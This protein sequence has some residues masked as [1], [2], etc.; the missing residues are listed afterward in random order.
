MRCCYVPHLATYPRHHSAHSPFYSLDSLDSLDP[1]SLSLDGHHRRTFE[2]LDGFDEQ[3]DRDRDSR[4]RSSPS[5]AEYCKPKYTL[6]NTHSTQSPG[7]DGRCEYPAPPLPPPV[8]SDRSRNQHRSRSINYSSCSLS[9]SL[10]SSPLSDSRFMSFQ[11]IRMHLRFSQVLNRSRDNTTHTVDATI[12]G[13]IRMHLNDRP[14]LPL[15]AAS[16]PGLG[17]HGVASRR[18]G[19]PGLKLSDIE[20][21]GSRA[22]AAGLAQGRPSVL[23][24]PRK[25]PSAGENGTP[26]ANFSKIVYVSASLL[27]FYIYIYIYTYTIPLSLSLSLSLY[28]FLLLSR[29]PSGALRFT[30]KAVLHAKGV[31]FS[32]GASFSINMSEFNLQ[33]ELGKGFYG[34]VRK[35]LHKPT[36]VLMAM[37]VPPRSPLS[38]SFLPPS[39]LTPTNRKSAFN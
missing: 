12:N 13:F 39:R 18:L 4:S 27:P 15:A 8:L 1:S 2:L 11:I 29:D 21:V 24:P 34:T 30:D 36:N 35:V 17:A 26:F 6:C 10:S 33:D 25:P 20:G 3:H 28:S 32:S 37:K 23:T 38:S 9:C 22:K 31:N 5:T 7:K 19:R 16:T 14:P